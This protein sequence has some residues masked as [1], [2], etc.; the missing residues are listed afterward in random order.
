MDDTL[1]SVKSGAKFAKDSNDWVLLNPKVAPTVKKLSEDGFKIVIFT[2]QAGIQKG[3]TNPEHIKAKVANIAQNIG[4]EMQVFV[5]SHEDE[6]RKP[7]T[8]MWELFTQKYNGKSKV[9]MKN[10]FYCGDAAGRK[11]GK[12][13]DFSDSDYKFA[14]N[15]GLP[16]KTPDNL[17]LGEKDK[18]EIKGFNP[19]AVPEE[20]ELIVGKGNK[21]SFVEHEMVVMVGAPGSGKSSFTANYLPNYVRVNRDTLKTK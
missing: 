10:S 6:Y 9:D 19:T 18:L 20:G 21:V 17:F 13:K 5:A 7:G 8:A 15:V 1:I 12:F 3:H 4:V 2:N 14:L 16:F 11:Y